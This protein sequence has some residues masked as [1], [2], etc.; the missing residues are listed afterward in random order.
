M[1]RNLTVF[2]IRQ[3]LRDDI[4]VKVVPSEVDTTFVKNTQPSK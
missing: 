1:K 4:P 3:F 2:L